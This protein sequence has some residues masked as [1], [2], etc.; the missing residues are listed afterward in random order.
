[1]GHLG[2]RLSNL[3]RSEGNIISKTEK[4]PVFDDVAKVV[5][6]SCENELISLTL[7]S[8]EWG[9]YLSIER[10]TLRVPGTRQSGSTKIATSEDE[11]RRNY[12]LSL[13]RIVTQRLG[14]NRM[15]RDSAH[16]AVR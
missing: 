15:E 16:A 5:G 8:K 4:P 14:R 3:S 2:R 11:E 12:G 6:S 13:I 10:R 7:V 1:M 9:V